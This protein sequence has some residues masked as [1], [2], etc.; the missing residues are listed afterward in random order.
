M[1][2]HAAAIGVLRQAIDLHPGFG[3]A[4]Y[5]LGTALGSI[6]QVDEAIAAYQQAIAWKP[7]LA[8]AHS[9]LGN[10]LQ[11]KGQHTAAL[12]CYDRALAFAP[13]YPE[14]LTNRGNALTSLGRNAEAEAMHEQ[15]IKHRPDFAEAHYNL[16][17]AYLE[18]MK[19]PEAIEC[20]RRSI[21]LRPDY[22]EAHNNLSMLLLLNGQ[23]ADG[24]QEYEWRWKVPG[25]PSPTRH[26]R[27]PMWNGA[28]ATPGCDT[29]LVHAEQGLGDTI[30][31]V[32]YLPLVKK[33]GWH[34]VFECFQSQKRLISL[35]VDSLGIDQIV[36]RAEDS[37]I[38]IADAALPAFHVHLPLLSLPR[39]LGHIDP[40]D[41]AIPAPPYLKADEELVARFRDEPLLADTGVFKVGLI[42]AGRP[43]HRADAKRSMA[44]A[45]LAPLAIS[46]VRLYSLQF[47]AAADQM[48][49]A[50]AQRGLTDLTP[51]LGDFADTAACLKQ[52]DLLIAVDTASVHLAGALGLPAWALI[53]F[54]PDFRWIIG[55]NDTPWYPSVRLYRQEKPGDWSSVVRSVARD[56]QEAARAAAPAAVAV[57]SA[58]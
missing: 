16:G 55:R 19:I 21:N 43:T 13:T 1:G 18:Q 25:F 17:V 58:S 49:T 2:Q 5:N 10:L 24:W 30:Q 35:V 53:A 52:L 3:E 7:A 39:V 33:L 9:N 37:P 46:G 32:R 57:E 8:Q 31:F 50:P 15:A 12:A 28:A 11:G 51:L 34:M 40:A 4:Y 22:P 48:L 54:V 23:F 38:E 26:F 56:L 20:F 44:L 36:T 42:W 14:A 29:I 45:D 27:Q 6:G 41:P 47:G